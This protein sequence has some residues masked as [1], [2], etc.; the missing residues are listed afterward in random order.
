VCRVVML[1]EA[2]GDAGRIVG[3]MYGD[4]DDRYGRAELG[5]WEGGRVA[6]DGGNGRLNVERTNSR[7]QEESA[8]ADGRK[9]ST[10]GRM[11]SSAGVGVAVAVGGGGSGDSWVRRGWDWRRA[12]VAVAAAVAVDGEQCANT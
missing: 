9:A 7:E 11:C 6:D 5:N 8:R 2:S 1:T 3:R 12:R 4:D 10:S